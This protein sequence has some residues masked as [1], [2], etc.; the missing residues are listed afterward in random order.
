MT[1][2]QTCAL[3]IFTY[4]DRRLR[5]WGYLRG[6]VSFGAICGIGIAAGNGVGSYLVGTEQSSW[7]FAGLAAAAMSSVWNYAV[8]SVLTWKRK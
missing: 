6:L 3:P 7:W 5:G 8:S 2:V 4:S 1:G